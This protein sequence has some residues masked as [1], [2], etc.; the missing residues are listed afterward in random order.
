MVVRPLAD[1]FHVLRSDDAAD[2]CNHLLDDDVFHN[3]RWN[4][5][6][7]QRTCDRDVLKERFARGEINPAEYEERRRLLET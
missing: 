3:A 7:P 5:A 2:L 4:G 6:L 1:A